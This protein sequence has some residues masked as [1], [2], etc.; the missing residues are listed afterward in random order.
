MTLRR[1]FQFDAAH[2]LSN[3]KGKCANL[4]GHTYTGE[5]E[6]RGDKDNETQMVVDFNDI[7]FIIDSYDHC[8][9]FSSPEFRGEAEEELVKWCIDNQ[10]KCKHIVG[11]CTA[12]NI[13]AQL[14]LDFIT[15]PKVHY[16]KVWLH[17]TPDS[18]VISEMSDA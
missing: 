6:L 1:K 4:H 8:V 9:L 7:K 14:C 5:I 3:Y 2:M 15:F 12:E 18:T 16:V 11:K 13:S 17:E 10:L